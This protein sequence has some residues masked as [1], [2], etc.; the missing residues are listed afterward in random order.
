VVIKIAGVIRLVNCTVSTETYF[1]SNY[2]PLD[3]A[4]WEYFEWNPLAGIDM[5]MTSDL[6]AERVMKRG[7][8]MHHRF[9][10]YEYLHLDEWRINDLYERHATKT[11]LWRYIGRTDDII[12]LG[13]GEKINPV[14]FEKLDEG[15]PGIEGDVRIVYTSLRVKRHEDKQT[16]IQTANTSALIHRCY[17]LQP[18]FTLPC[19]YPSSPLCL[20]LKLHPSY[21]PI[22]HPLYLSGA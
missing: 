13:N 10:L 7:L 18:T 17:I 20:L 15:H 14:P 2:I 22:P 19:P 8:D 16:Q 1:T 9:A 6:L 21:K 5:K 4:D 3:P 11:Q 12:V